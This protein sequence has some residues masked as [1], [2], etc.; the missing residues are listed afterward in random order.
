M[1]DRLN[2]PRS[3]LYP[4]DKRVIICPC[5]FPDNYRAVIDGDRTRFSWLRAHL[6]RGGRTIYQTDNDSVQ[7]PLLLSRGQ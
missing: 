1:I 3:T 7:L 5:K 4:N 2:N 6:L